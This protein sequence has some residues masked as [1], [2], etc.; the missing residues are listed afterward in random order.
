MDEMRAREEEMIREKQSELLRLKYQLEEMT[1]RSQ[2]LD[3]K[4]EN[5]DLYK[6]EQVDVQQQRLEYLVHKND[7]VEKKVTEGWKK[8]GVGEGGRFH[9]LYEQLQERLQ[10]AKNE[11][12]LAELQY[13][14]FMSQIE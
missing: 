4:L 6:Q 1:E 5:K 12:R 7:Q 10:D 9:R 2:K 13:K 8:L 11:E 3:K 14:T